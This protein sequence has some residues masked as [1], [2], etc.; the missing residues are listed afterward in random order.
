[1]VKKSAS[2]IKFVLAV[3]MFFMAI[4]LLV[5]ALFGLSIGPLIMVSDFAV[6]LVFVWLH[7]R[8]GGWR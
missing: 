5:S 4:I 7:G 3:V 6:F 1:M 8:Q 2:I